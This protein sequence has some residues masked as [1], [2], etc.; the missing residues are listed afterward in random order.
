MVAKIGH[1]VLIQTHYNRGNF[2]KRRRGCSW[3][4]IVHEAALARQKQFDNTL[5]TAKHADQNE[6][7]QRTRA[8][9]SHSSSHL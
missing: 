7:H 5:C 4:L 2:Y 8:S 3:P 1:V 6:P 9:P